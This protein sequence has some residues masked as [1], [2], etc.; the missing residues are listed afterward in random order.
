MGITGEQKIC[1]AIPGQAVCDPE[2]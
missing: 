2:G 1:K